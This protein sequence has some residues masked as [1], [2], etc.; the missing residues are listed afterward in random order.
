MNVLEIDGASNN[1]VEDVR[2]LLSSR[3]LLPDRDVDVALEQLFD[4]IESRA[5]DCVGQVRQFGK[6]QTPGFANMLARRLFQITTQQHQP[7]A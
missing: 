6:N 2:E 5:I 4:R 1:S 3:G 7:T